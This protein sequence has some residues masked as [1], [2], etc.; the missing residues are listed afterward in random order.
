MTGV[1][2]MAQVP[3]ARESPGVRTVAGPHIEREIRSLMGAPIR[4]CV[5]ARP[6]VVSHAGSERTQIGGERGVG[7]SEGI[8]RTAVDPNRHPG[9][10]F[11][12][13]GR[14]DVIPF[15][16]GRI[17]EGARRRSAGTLPEG[18]GVTTDGA[19]HARAE[20]CQVQ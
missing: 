12:T 10:S 3:L 15:E 20:L 7:G 19:K 18:G 1:S 11:R 6:N 17:V 4:T 9:E 16:V 2:R 13:R 14:E 5:T 8:T